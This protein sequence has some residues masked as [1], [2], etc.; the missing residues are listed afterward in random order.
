MTTFS[1]DWD[2]IPAYLRTRLG[3]CKDEP[4]RALTTVWFHA[5][6]TPDWLARLDESKERVGKTPMVHLG[7]QRSAEDRALDR[8]FARKGDWFLYAVTLTPKT[9]LYPAVYFDQEE[10]WEPT[11]RQ[12]ETEGYH[13][14]VYLNDYEDNGSLSLMVNADHI[15][16]IALEVRSAPWD[17]CPALKNRVRSYA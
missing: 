9:L 7:T 8:R 2:T 15:N 12:L 1:V 3:I 10:A 13:G 17:A 14:L 5:T 11:E 4:A 16:V 6:D